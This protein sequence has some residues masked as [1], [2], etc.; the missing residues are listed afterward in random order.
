MITSNKAIRLFLI[1]TFLF[2][3]TMWGIMILAQELKWF[4]YGS[5]FSMVLQI[6]AGNGPAIIVYFVFK[7][8]KAVFSFRQ[9]LREAFGLK[10]KAIYYAITISLIGIFFAIPAVMGG[11]SSRLEPFAGG[12]EGAA[13]MPIWITIVA[14]PL[15]FFL[16]GSEELGWRHFLGPAF[17]K[18]M[19]FTY[20]TLLTATIWCAW[21][22][23]LFLITGTTQNSHGPSFLILFAIGIF[24]NAFASAAI[25][26]VSKSAWLCILFHCATNALQGSLPLTNDITI[27]AVK[28]AVLIAV[29]L[30]IVYLSNRQTIK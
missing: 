14:I 26:R 8:Y 30:V 9:Y 11:I 6:L 3:W 7:K 1:G 29:S 16:G 18:K 10:Q 25:Y 5:P 23:P 19:S 21:H 12:T 27:Y 24:G 20:A 13:P 2:S 4:Q 17:E 28:A 15:F 22:L